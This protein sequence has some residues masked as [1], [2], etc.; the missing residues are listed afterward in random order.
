M[1]SVTNRTLLDLG[2]LTANLVTYPE[3]HSVYRHNDPMGGGRYY[4]LNLILKAPRAGGVFETEKVI[5][6]LFDRV[7][8]FRPDLYQHS[9]SK[10][11]KGKRVRLSIALHTP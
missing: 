5:F 1:A 2:R 8:L 9:V 11:E 6:N 3:G 10:I 7:I 4:K